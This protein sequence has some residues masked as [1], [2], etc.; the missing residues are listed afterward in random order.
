M[1]LLLLRCTWPLLRRGRNIP[2]P[3]NRSR[4]QL[5]AIRRFINANHW[6]DWHSETY[7]I[8]LGDLSSWHAIL[9]STTDT[10]E[11]LG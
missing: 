4:R 6:S 5:T 1:P 3:S 11:G 8:K 7:A 9:V 10:C 2:E